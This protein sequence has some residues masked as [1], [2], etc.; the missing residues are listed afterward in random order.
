MRIQLQ[1][2]F[3]ECF[4]NLETFTVVD[5][6]CISPKFSGNQAATGTMS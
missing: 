4:V 2:G 1:F 3:F 6:P 5:L